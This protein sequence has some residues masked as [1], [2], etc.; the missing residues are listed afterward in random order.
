MHI[1]LGLLG[2]V[3]VDHEVEA[4]D[5]ESACGHVGRDEYRELAGL[6][7][8]D[9]LQALGLGKIAH[10]ELAVDAVDPEPSRDLLGHVFLIAE[11]E[12]ALG[13]FPFEDAEEEAEL[14]VVAHVVKFL[15]DEIDG[16]VLGLDHYLVGSVHVFPGEV[17]DAETESRRE[18]ECLPLPR[19]VKDSAGAC[20][21]RR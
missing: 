17:L 14:L 15:G 7:P 2:Q 5:I 20:A 3:V 11:N 4:F 12:R 6:E 13:L 19:W 8:V 9:D 10:D 18:E 1:G 16:H 21:D